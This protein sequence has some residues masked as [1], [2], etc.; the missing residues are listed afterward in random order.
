MALDFDGTDAQESSPGNQNRIQINKN[1][2]T[3][4]FG[5]SGW[6]YWQSANKRG[7]CANGPSSAAPSFAVTILTDGSLETYRGTNTSST[8]KIQ[9]NQWNHFYIF[10]DGTT[11]F[12]YINGSFSNS[13]A[14]S[15]GGASQTE[16]YIGYNYWGAVNALLDDFRAYTRPL[17]PPE[18]RQ[19]A[20]RRGIGLQSTPR[21]TDYLETREKTYSVIVKSQQEHSSLSEGLVGAW[22]PS[23]SGATGY[24]IPD[25]SSRGN[26]LTL[27]VNANTKFIPGKN[28]ISVDLNGGRAEAAYTTN[29]T[30]TSNFTLSIWI[31]LSST[32]S[33]SDQLIPIF[34]QKA[35]NAADAG[36]MMYYWYGGANAGKFMHSTA[37]G[38]SRSEINI[39]TAV[40]I[41]SQWAHVVMVRNSALANGGTYYINGI[42]YPLAS[43][44]T[45][46]DVTTTSKLRIAQ[47][48][49]ASR[50]G[51]FT[52]DDARVYNRALTEPEIKRLASNP[53]VGL[54][55]QK[56][57]MFY[58]FPSGSKR[59]RILTGMT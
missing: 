33:A 36:I 20:S 30:G 43:A 37:N 55:S 7:I 29:I 23:V 16:F 48:A 10:N 44:I 45:I 28:G 24:T 38:S 19:L 11:T 15:V 46:W 2:V 41:T 5:V 26:A 35:V 17:T 53:N 57:T 52:W 47:D 59:R 42:E 49:S 34:G 12:Y 40:S 4:S 54:R 3:T 1:F 27:N 50:T 8:A 13:S 6:I 31:K 32:Q 9:L 39:A 18:I 51:N 58:Q 21:H 14:Q 22:C 25:A 56:Q